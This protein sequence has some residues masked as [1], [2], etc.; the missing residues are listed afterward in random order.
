MS[1]PARTL[2]AFFDKDKI[3]TD[4]CSGMRGRVGACEDYGRREGGFVVGIL[5]WDCT[6]RGSW[7]KGGAMSTN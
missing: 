5:C 2:D 4:A 7:C 1:E 6:S 3:D